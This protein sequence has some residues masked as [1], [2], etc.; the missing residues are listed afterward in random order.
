MA[1]ADRG[2]FARRKAAAGFCCVSPS[3]S[4]LTGV[5]PIDCSELYVNAENVTKVIDDWQAVLKAYM[6][7]GAAGDFESG[8]RKSNKPAPT[9]DTSI[10]YG[11]AKNVQVCWLLS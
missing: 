9:P 3:Q 7:A 11:Y 5:P 2:V 10:H 1:E 4:L 8:W 6:T